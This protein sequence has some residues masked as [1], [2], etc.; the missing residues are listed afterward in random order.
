MLL[1][2]FVQIESVFIKLQYMYSTVTYS[3]CAYVRHRYGTEQYVQYV[4]YNDM[5]VCIMYCMYSMH[6]MYSMYSI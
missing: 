5:I 4:L 1:P 2:L 6:N 3:R